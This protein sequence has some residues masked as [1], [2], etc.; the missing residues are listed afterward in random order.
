MAK[1]IVLSEG[2]TGRSIEL[3]SE[4]TTIGRVEDNMF[5]IAEPSV[6]SHHCEVYLKDNTFVVKDLGSTNGTYIEGSQVTESPLKPGQ[7]LRLGQV[8]LRLDDGTTPPAPSPKKALDHNQAVGIKLNDLSSGPKPVNPETDKIFK[9]KSNKIN[10]YFIAAGVI[11]AL[12]VVG[13]IVKAML[14]S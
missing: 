5:Q 1:L 10:Q 2:L 14:G 11:L 4:R 13:L 9:K 6:S 12:V 8:E 7:T 3:K